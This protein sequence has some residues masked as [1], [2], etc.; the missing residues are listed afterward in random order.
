MNTKMTPD[1]MCKVLSKVSLD[2]TLKDGVYMWIAQHLWGAPMDFEGANVQDVR[3]AVLQMS[4]AVALVEN[5]TRGTKWRWLVRKLDINEKPPY[6]YLAN[7]CQGC[8]SQND[9]IHRHSLALL[10]NTA[11]I[12]SLIQV[13]DYERTRIKTNGA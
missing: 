1:V 12:M 8:T 2:V 11:L 6:L 5:I 4:H 7:I 9:D 3:Y 10:P 13:V